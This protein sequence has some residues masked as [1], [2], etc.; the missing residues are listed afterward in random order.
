MHPR[1]L[2]TL[3]LGQKYLGTSWRFL[4]NTPPPI[5]GNV[6]PIVADCR[7]AFSTNIL[8]ICLRVSCQYTPPFGK[9]AVR[10]SAKNRPSI[11]LDW[12]KYLDFSQYLMLD[13]RKFP[14]F[15]RF[16]GN[17]REFWGSK[18]E[19]RPST[20]RRGNQ[21]TDKFGQLV[22]SKGGGVLIRFPPA[23][24]KD[25]CISGSVAIYPRRRAGLFCRKGGVYW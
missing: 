14:F 13:G 7:Q 11:V 17:V 16:F 6:Q 24:S 18:R 21:L 25:N 10:T 19:V 20:D 3:I 15:P 8:W 9:Y 2:K 1:P 12:Q 22:F 23:D 4:V 5:D